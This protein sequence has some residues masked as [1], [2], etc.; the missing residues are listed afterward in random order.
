M[1]TLLHNGI[2]LTP[3]ERIEGGWLL[4]EGGKIAALGQ[5]PPPV[6]Q[7]TRRIDAAG[8]FI[9]PGFIDL[10]AQGFR[11]YDLWDPPEE[12]FLGAARQMAAT[13]VTA[14]QASVD[15][16][17]AVCRIMRPR[18]GRAGGGTRILGLYF[19][20]P[21]ISPARRGAIPLDRVRPPSMDRARDILS[22]A[23]GILSMIT[24]APELPGALD[25]VRLFRSV[26]GPWGP[27]VVALGHTAATYEQAVAGLEA[28]M[29]HCTHLY[30]AMPAMGHREPGAAGAILAHPVASVEII[31]DG[32]HLH[33]AVVRMAVACKGAA[34]TCLITDCVSGKHAG[35]ADGAPRLADGTLAGSVLSMDRAVANV[36]RFAGVT[37]QQAVEMATLSPA[38]AMGCDRTKGSLAPGK[39]AD[40]ILFDR[41]VAVSLTLVGGE[42]VYQQ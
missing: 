26:A 33:P 24:I 16:A 9:A 2:V 17:E 6:A 30:N 27:V 3:A 42:V 8:R 23:S 11:G 5:G 13:G 38:R 21:F 25:L 10:H 37:L 41:D 40:V 35:V 14:A 18:I 31:C 29:T 12:H 39:D 34:R 28:G 22:H 7:A 32:V 1:K 19:E 20:A 36:M 15:P 4:L